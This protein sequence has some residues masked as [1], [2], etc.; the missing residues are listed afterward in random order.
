MLHQLLHEWILAWFAFIERT[1]YWGVF[2]FMALESSIVPV[3]SEI[4]MPPAAYWASQ[5]KMSFWGVVAAGTGGSYFGSIISYYVARFVGIPFLNRF[6]K[7]VFLPAEKL[8][9]AEEVLRKHGVLGVFVSRLLPVIRHLISIPAGVFRM[10]VIPFSIVTTV[11]AFLWCT[12]LSWFGSATI[13]KYPELLQSPDQLILV[14]KAEL[15]KFVWGVLVFAAL[16]AV[17]V[18]WKKRSRTAQ[19]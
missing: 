8:A 11:G 5:G 14:M 19:T 1:G 17:M 6:G 15:A 2:F 7:Y 16:Y 10:P 9:F 13:G 18:I 3:P 12:V 4:V